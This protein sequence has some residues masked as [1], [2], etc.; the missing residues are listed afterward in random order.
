MK[1]NNLYLSLSLSPLNLYIHQIKPFISYISTADVELIE[2]SRS[3]G[4][5][6]GI[7]IRS[8]R[9]RSGIFV[10]Y[11]VPGSVAGDSKLIHPG[12]RIL[13]ANGHDL[14][15]ASVDDAAT[16]MSVSEEKG[17][18]GIEGA[19]EQEGEREGEREGGEE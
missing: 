19:R 7:Q 8:S 1:V 10:Y 14:R 15:Q 12:D 17:E 9:S 6:L 16:Y 11:L 3:E 4:S 2:L 5:P 18:G 13:E